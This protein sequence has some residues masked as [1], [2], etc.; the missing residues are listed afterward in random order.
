M[1]SRR[2]VAALSAAVFGAATL[3]IAPPSASAVA[4]P[5][6]ITALSSEPNGDGVLVR[7]QSRGSNTDYYLLKTGL[8]SF[9]AASSGRFPTTIR[10]S[11]LARSYRLNEL[12]LARAGAAVGT[13]RQVYYRLYA[14]NQEGSSSKS[15][16]YPAIRAALP[17]GL[18]AKKVGTVVRAATFNVRTAK[19]TW[20]KRHWMK[21][22]A[23]VAAEIKASKAD[24]VAIQE[25]SPGRQDGKDG[26]TKK[27][28]R[29]TTSLLTELKKIGMGHFKLVRETQYKKPGTI[30][31]TQGTRILYNT[32]KY[33]L[34]SKCPEKTG[35]KYWNPACSID[36]P[37][38]KGDSGK[39]KRKAAYA[40][41]EDKFTGKRFYMVSAHLDQRHSGRR[42]P[43]RS[44][45]RCGTRRR[46][47]SST[48]WTRSTPRTGRSSSALTSTPTRTASSATR[49]TT[50]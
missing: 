36:L 39:A 48:G 43:R 49:R 37:I 30:H 29:Q 9:S 34:L 15:R 22:K 24:V 2:I 19:A 7:W 44:T 35:K 5:D 45:T 42:R 25:M 16:A 18:A 38:M 4:D 40:A 32:R 27:V 1:I 20:D 8:T 12:D 41:F 17:P 3:L 28:G 10:V 26:S 11:A 47:R 31:G 13:G 46:R 21:R 14:V 50:G 33:E 6:A 23:L